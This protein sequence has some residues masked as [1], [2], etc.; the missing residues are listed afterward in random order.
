MFVFWETAGLLSLFYVC[1]RIYLSSSLCWK[2]SERPKGWFHSADKCWLSGWSQAKGNKRRSTSVVVN[3][4][5][6]AW[7]ASLA[8]SKGTKAS[9]ADSLYTNCTASG[10]KRVKDTLK[11]LPPAVVP[12]GTAPA[13]SSANCCFSI[14][15]GTDS[16]RAVSTC[17]SSFASNQIRTKTS[18]LKCCR[19]TVQQK[20]TW[21]QRQQGRRSVERRRCFQMFGHLWRSFC[22]WWSGRSVL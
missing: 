13:G 4:N 12:Q 1:C 15:V 21:S 10:L 3:I 16:G 19:L 8:L 5:T 11:S 7:T 20:Q 14:P 18:R 2:E 22:S 9:I 17:F 6:Q